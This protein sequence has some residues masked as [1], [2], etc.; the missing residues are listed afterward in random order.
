MPLN[1]STAKCRWRKPS[2]MWYNIVICATLCVNF[3]SKSRVTNVFPKNILKSKTGDKLIQATKKLFC[4]VMVKIITFAT[5]C[6]GFCASLKADEGAKSNKKHPSWFTVL[7]YDCQ[8]Q[9]PEVFYKKTILKSSLYPQKTPVYESPL[10]NVAGLKA[11][12][13]IKK[14]PQWRCFP[15]NIAK[16]LILLILKNICERLLFDFFNGSL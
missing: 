11:C 12:Y 10:K 9:S 4:H 7:W 1:W 14:R 16:F 3:L 13:F 15:V 8:K 5:F 2:D 6:V